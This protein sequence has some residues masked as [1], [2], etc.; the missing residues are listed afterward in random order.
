[1][2]GT[3]SGPALI[4]HR[5][6]NV[7]KALQDHLIQPSPYHQHHYPLNHVPKHDVQPF[8]KHPQEWGLCQTQYKVLEDLLS[9]FMHPIHM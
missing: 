8:L 6:I 1:M 4:N 5:T 9:D 7:E 2:G 3:T